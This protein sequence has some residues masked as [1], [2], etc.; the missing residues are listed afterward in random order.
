MSKRKL[1]KYKVTKVNNI[2]VIDILKDR[3]IVNVSI[4]D[5]N[6]NKRTED[7]PFSNIF[8]AQEL[9]EG[10]PIEIEEVMNIK[11]SLKKVRKGKYKW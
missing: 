2:D 3:I 4:I 6:G 10:D 1:I 5:N 9:K 8:T 7:L 11:E